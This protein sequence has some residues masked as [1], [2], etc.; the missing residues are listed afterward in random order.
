MACGGAGGTPGQWGTQPGGNPYGQSSSY[1]PNQTHA[2]ND[3]QQGNGRVIASWSENGEMAA[4]E[5]ALEHGF[6][7]PERLV[8]RIQHGD[9]NAEGE[10]SST[11]CATFVVGTPGAVGRLQ[12]RVDVHAVQ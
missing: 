5:R 7:P 6:E 8:V 2:A 3:I 9:E 1:N 12:R 11:G 10:Y 4:G